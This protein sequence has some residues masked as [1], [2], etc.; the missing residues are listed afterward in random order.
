MTSGEPEAPVSGVDFS[1]PP[2]FLQSLLLQPLCLVPLADVMPGT[3][4]ADFPTDFYFTPSTRLSNAF[5]L[6]LYATL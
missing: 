2:T 5:I 4:G 1:H 6:V 3:G